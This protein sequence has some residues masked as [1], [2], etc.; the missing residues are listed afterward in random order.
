MVEVPLRSLGEHEVVVEYSEHSIGSIVAEL[1][2]TNLVRVE[3]REDGRGVRH[4]PVLRIIRPRD[5]PRTA[6]KIWN[7]ES[8]LNKLQGRP[9]SVWD[10]KPPAGI[11]KDSRS[12][13]SSS[14][15]QPFVTPRVAE[16]PLEQA[17][18]RS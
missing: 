3:D 1:W 11:S 16:P 4:K 13:T 9:R 10:S 2:P 15:G 8:L 14:Q 18:A 17:S 12:R 7:G 5:P 6:T